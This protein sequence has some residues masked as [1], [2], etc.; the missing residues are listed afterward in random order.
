MSSFVGTLGR[1]TISPIDNER[2]AVCMYTC[3]PQA[4]SECNTFLTDCKRRT[5]ASEVAVKKFQVIKP[6]ASAQ[7]SSHGAC[8]ESSYFAHWRSVRKLI[9]AVSYHE[10][11]EN[12]C[13]RDIDIC[14]QTTLN[15]H[16]TGSKARL[17]GLRVCEL[18]ARMLGC[19]AYPDLTLPA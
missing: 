12:P 6:T 1:C 2:C 13:L 17:V 5:K 11:F 19:R 16:D 7:T 18:R 15:Q 3:I 9:V 10:G 8:V 14:S 4:A